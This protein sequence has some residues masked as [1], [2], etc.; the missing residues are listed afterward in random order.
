MTV[1]WFWSAVRYPVTPAGWLLRFV[2]RE[3]NVVA[4]SELEVRLLTAELQGTRLP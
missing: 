3:P 4:P 2:T 1:G